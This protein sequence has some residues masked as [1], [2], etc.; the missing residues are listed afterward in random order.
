M[1]WQL[2]LRCIWCKP[3]R[4]AVG[5]SPVALRAPPCSAM[6][7]WRSGSEILTLKA[8]SQPILSLKSFQ[9][10][11]PRP[12]A[13]PQPR[14]AEMLKKGINHTISVCCLRR[15]R[16]SRGSRGLPQQPPSMSG[17]HPLISLIA[18]GN[19]RGIWQREHPSEVLGRAGGSAVPRGWLAWIPPHRR[20]PP[21][22]QT[23]KG[24]FGGGTPLS[25]GKASFQVEKKPAPQQYE[26]VVKAQGHPLATCPLQTPGVTQGTIP[27]G[28]QE[29]C[30]GV[31]PL[32][33][34]GRPPWA[35]WEPS[36][37]RS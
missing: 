20:S 35:R 37:S 10:C 16:A 29:P 7:P 6:A 26:G 34:P 23:G 15:A 17:F 2:I 27:R 24:P 28:T 14:A 32:S 31:S 22:I 19:R 4:A 33:L 3:S 18:F 1:F 12:M 30:P 21:H 9:E 13:L 36:A 25:S 8:R 11:V 5:G